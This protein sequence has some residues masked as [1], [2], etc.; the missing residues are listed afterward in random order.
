MS[1]TLLE[2]R[3]ARKEFTLPSSLMTRL[4]GKARR[5]TA[6][7][8]VTVLVNQGEILGLVGESGSGKSTLAQMAVRLV[9]PTSGSVLYRGQDVMSL[10]GDALRRYRS[11]VQMVFQDSHSSLNPRK[12]IATTMAEPLRIRGLTASEATGE[13]ER[14]LELV[15]MDPVFLRRFPHELSGGQRQRIGIA[16]A[17][18]MKPEFLVADEPVSSLDVSLQAQITNLLLRLK[19]ELDLTI[20]FISHDLALVNFLADRVAV[21]ELGKIVETGHPETV[22]RNPAHPYTRRLLDAVPRGIERHRDDRAVS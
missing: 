3:Q 13:A 11:S 9:A 14:L 20:L 2:F 1:E 4:L 8:D 19:A 17:L 15:G 7:D 18:A 22:L 21:M 10:S 6:V 16:R 5:V 12:R